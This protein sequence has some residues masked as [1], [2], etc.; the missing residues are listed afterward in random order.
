MTCGGEMDNSNPSRRIFSIKI[1]SWSS[2][3]PLTINSSDLSP[4]F[5]IVTVTFLAASLSN[6]SLMCNAEKIL[7]SFPAK[8]ELFTPNVME[9]TGG[10]IASAPSAF[11]S[12]KSQRVDD[13]ET[14]L[15]PATDTMS[16][17]APKSMM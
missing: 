4:L 16:P 7:P 12:F 6:L 11:V 3:R 15:N 1:L 14:L 2:P 8:G 17:A 9:R 10:S 13:T 5:E